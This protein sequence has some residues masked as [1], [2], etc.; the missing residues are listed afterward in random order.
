LS[1]GASTCHLSLDPAADCAIVANYS[2]GNISV[3]PIQGDGKIAPP[4]NVI[5]HTGSSVNP[6]RQKHPYPHSCN[7]DPSGRFVLV[8]DL[9]TDQIY[10]YSFDPAKR[11]LAA[12]DPA[13]VRVAPGSG[14]RHLAFSPDGKF[15]YLV[16][17][18]IP[19]IVAYAFD[20]QTGRLRELQTISTL[21]GP[22]KPTDS[23]AEIEVHPNGKFVYA[24][25][26]GLDNIAVF[27]RDPVQGTLTAA[28]YQ[29]T[30]GKTPRAFAID[31]TGNFLLAGNQDSDSVAI[32]RIDPG[33]GAL[34]Q[35]A[36]LPVPTPVSFA[37]LAVP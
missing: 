32:L 13:T 17:E 3:L 25:N 31:P 34:T 22:L 35:T 30:G 9:G 6:D 10:I 36:M 33:T 2:S 11:T 8:P 29:S 7:F 21:P 14:P 1:R 5:Q 37:F 20:A 16:N 27:R 23:G 4:S 24:S 18:L 15:A 28:G 12:A 19:S 26:R